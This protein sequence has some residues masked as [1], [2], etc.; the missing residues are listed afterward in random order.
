VAL[1]EGDL[2]METTPE[3]LIAAIREAVKPLEL[4]IEAIEAKPV[5][6]GLIG[7]LHD[8]VKGFRTIIVGT[9]FAAV[10]ALVDYLGQIDVGSVF[11]LSPKA[12]VLVGIVMVFMRLITHGP[13]PTVR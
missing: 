6:R 8:K 9:L 3:A 10:P 4:R 5:A 11:G 7:R 12:G 2:I 13:V 1:A